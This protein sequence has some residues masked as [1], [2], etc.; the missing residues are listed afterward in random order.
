MNN[1]SF[2]ESLSGEIVDGQYLWVNAFA[3]SPDNAQWSGRSYQHKT[4]QQ[5][6]INEAADQNT[7]FCPALLSGL[8]DSGSFKRSKAHFT[9]LLALVAD[10]ADPD[11]VVGSLSWLIETSEN[12]YQMGILVDLD[13]PD[14]ADAQTVD[15][16]MQAMADASLIKADKSGNNAVRYLRLPNG[17]NTKLRAN[18][19]S[20]RVRSMDLQSRYSLADACA[21]FGLDLE[22][23]KQYSTVVDSDAAKISGADH[24]SLIA[25]LAADVP[26]DRSY[27][28]PLLKLSSK[29]VK[30]GTS[31][32]AVVEHLRG[33]MLAVRPTDPHEYQRWEERYNEIP[34]M[35]S[36]AERYR[37]PIIDMPVIDGE[38]DGSLLVDINEL[39]RISG[40]IRWLVK[41]LVPADAMGMLFGASGAFKSFIALD[42]GLH[43][44]HG[45]NWCNRK[46]TQGNVVYVAAEGGAGVYRRIKAWHEKRG[47]GIT[48]NF[49]ICI[50]P[51]LLTVE[52]EIDRLAQAIAAL[53]EPPSLVVIDT[54]SQTFSGDENSSTDIADYIRSMNTKLRAQYGC[55]VLILHHTGHSASERPRGSSAITANLDFLL[56]CYR[57]DKDS[58]SAQLEVFKQKDGDKLDTQWFTLESK[59]IGVDDDGEKIQSLV[60]S[61]NDLVANLKHNAAMLNQNERDVL[62]AIP[63]AGTATEQEMQDALMHRYENQATRYKTLQRAIKKLYNEK[64]LIIPVGKRIW[65]R[66]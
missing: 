56:G 62:D 31:G 22:Q 6:L 61:W 46:T 63:V 64:N 14:A 25:A 44:A 1:A 60:A 17:V 2:L 3:T 41:G 29:L 42:F 30:A 13:D 8:D 37:Q 35:V 48:D 33:L 26:K 45:L 66:A 58:L 39:E 51:L 20:V 54:L 40:N 65:R 7:Y 47:L 59:E 19:W 34:R 49:S 11:D 38:A 4:A 53:P 12:N 27:H 24:A 36:G 57:P 21:A 10:D 5:I 16:V 23:I 32:G 50:T 55:S 28:D 52:D 18:N 43:V 15:A 9:K